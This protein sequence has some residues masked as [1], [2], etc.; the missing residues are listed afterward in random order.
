M[1]TTTKMGI[2][3]P[4]ST[5][6]VK[7]G[8]TAMGTIATTVDAK[9]GMVLLNTT[10]LTAVSSVSVNDVFSANYDAY[11]VLLVI[12]SNTFGDGNVRMRLRVSGSDNSSANYFTQNSG[13]TDFNATDNFR[14]SSSTSWFVSGTNSGGTGAVANSRIDIFNP[15]KAVR[16]TTSG[17]SESEASSGAMTIFNFGQI[18]LD[19]TSFTGFTIFATSGNFATGKVLTYGYNQ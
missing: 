7:D 5:D 6:L 19:T 17:Q 13:F 12:D 15:F 9:T 1:P 18:H 16:T 10:N 2:V 11:K 3:Y 8:A 4:S 14:E